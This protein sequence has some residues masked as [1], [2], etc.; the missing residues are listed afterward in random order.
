MITQEQKTAICEEYANRQN[1]VT[2]IATKYHLQRAEVVRIAVEMGGTPRCAKRFGKKHSQTGKPVKKRVCPKCDKRNEISDARFCY[3]CGSD[4]RTE[5][6]ICIDDL[7]SITPK[8]QFLPNG[9]RDEFY[10]AISTAIKELST[11]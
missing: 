4:I 10:R 3:Y 9:M 8:V 1:K 7:K 11:D 5:K 2:N 6:Q